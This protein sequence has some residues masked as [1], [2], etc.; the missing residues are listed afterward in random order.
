VRNR[1]RGPPLRQPVLLHPHP[2]RPLLPPAGEGEPSSGRVCKKSG[3][4][5]ARLANRFDRKIKPLGKNRGQTLRGWLGECLL[6]L[7]RRR[8]IRSAKSIAI[9]ALRLSPIPW[10]RLGH[11]PPDV[12]LTLTSGKWLGS[13]RDRQCGLGQGS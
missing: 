13:L 1:N 6:C 5:P 7:R 11:A 9:R 12:A 2:P 8:P 4:D 3:T 10:L